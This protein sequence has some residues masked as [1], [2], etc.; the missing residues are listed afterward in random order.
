MYTK[1]IY[2]TVISM[3]PFY[4][5]NIWNWMRTL[6]WDAPMRFYLDVQLEKQKIERDLSRLKDSN[7][8]E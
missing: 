8:H 1:A 7:T 5:E 6:V 4:A 3:A 2:R